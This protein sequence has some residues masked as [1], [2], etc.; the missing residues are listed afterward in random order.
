M[1]DRGVGA[2]STKQS[3]EENLKLPLVV[4]VADQSATHGSLRSNRHKLKEAQ[5]TFSTQ[6]DKYQVA[7]VERLNTTLA[8]QKAG[9]NTQMQL[10]YLSDTVQARASGGIAHVRKFESRSAS[11]G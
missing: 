5:S 9:A 2:L 11:Q 3:K 4:R 6:N 7:G 10:R 1:S 8:G